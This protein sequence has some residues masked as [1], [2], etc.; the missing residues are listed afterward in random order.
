MFCDKAVTMLYKDFGVSEV[1]NSSNSFVLE[2]SGHSQ[3]ISLRLFKNI[4]QIWIEQ[5]VALIWA[6]S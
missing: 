2:C 1:F 6:N 4:F 5:L 3:I